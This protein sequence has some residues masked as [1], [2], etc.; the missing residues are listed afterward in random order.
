MLTHPGAKNDREENMNST[1]SRP[2]LGL[3][4]GGGGVRGLAHVGF[5]KILEREGIQVDYIAGTSMG[6]IVGA[7]YAAQVPIA[8]IEALAL[9][10]RRLREVVKLVDLGLSTNGLMR[11]AR[12]YDFMAETLGVNITFA[13]LHIP[14]AMNAVDIISGRE[15]VFKEGRVVDAVRATISVPGVFEPVEIGDCRLVDGGLLNNVPVDIVR[16]LGAEVIIA[17]DVMPYFS[18]NQ[19]CRPPTTT[20]VPKSRAF[21]KMAHETWR[22][23]MIMIAAMTEYR[24]RETRPDLFIRPRLPDSMGLFVGFDRPHVAIDAGEQAAEAFLPQIKQ[25][26]G[27]AN[28]ESNQS[29]P[30]SEG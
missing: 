22:I 27:L 21:S 13:D 23:Q 2:K 5:L 29:G 18:D 1:N 11:G 19:P 4:L 26:V 6:G 17:I 14:L 20:P 25:L 10:A 30:A 28:E 7:L 8:E 24:L 15:V 12:V 3:A 9:Q 16:S